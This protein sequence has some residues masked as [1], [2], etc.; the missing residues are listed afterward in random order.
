MTGN[1]G[2]HDSSS[3][4]DSMS[5]RWRWLG[6][7]L[8]WLAAAAAVGV[9][10]LAIFELRRT[11]PVRSAPVVVDRLPTRQPHD[12]A[13]SWTVTEH[14]SAH[15][16]LIAHVET[17]LLNE[18]VAI[19]QQL[20]EPIKDKYAEVLIYFHRPGRPDTLPPRRVQW[21]RQGGYIETVYDDNGR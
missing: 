20:T 6:L 3:K 13:T 9:L 12:T 1:V 16:V 14:L 11:P 8:I 4:P 7:G 5:N 15:H 10:A 18:A 2:S 21:T 17:S 19:A